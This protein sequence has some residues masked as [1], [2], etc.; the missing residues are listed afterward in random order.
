MTGEEAGKYPSWFS[1]LSTFGTPDR[2]RAIG[3]ILDTFIPYVLLWV[4]MVY[5]LFM[6]APT[7]PSGR[8][9]GSTR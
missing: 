4:G 8:T 9:E 5:T 3:Q 2:A 7:V 1:K 6:I